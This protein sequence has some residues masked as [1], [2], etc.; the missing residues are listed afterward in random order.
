MIIIITS[1]VA[2]L[3]ISTIM[4]ISVREQGREIGMLRAIGISKGTIM[5]HILTES[6]IICILGFI[7]G[8]IMGYVG[9]GILNEIIRST[10]ESIPAGI[11]ITHISLDII[12]QVCLITLTIGI[13]AGVI[14][15]GWAA[16]LEP[17]ESIRKV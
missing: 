4:M 6:I 9:A 5:K 3:F 8:L 13:L 16:R 7:I 14:P 10:E 12:L 17:V 1:S 2:I 15:A 11:E